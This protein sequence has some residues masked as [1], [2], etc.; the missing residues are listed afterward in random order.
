MTLSQSFSKKG[1]T[2]SDHDKNMY[3]GLVVATQQVLDS[4]LRIVILS[5]KEKKRRA[6]ATLLRFLGL[7]VCG[8]FTA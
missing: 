7:K 5:E 3:L 2:C 8:C 4:S 6:M 1:L